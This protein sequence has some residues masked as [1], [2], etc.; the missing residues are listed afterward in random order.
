MNRYTDTHYMTRMHVNHSF[1]S[2]FLSSKIK[3]R[4]RKVHTLMYF[5]RQLYI[6]C[7]DV[8]SYLNNKENL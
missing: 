6:D 3:P 7:L 1:M 8:K 4:N 5:H 2:E